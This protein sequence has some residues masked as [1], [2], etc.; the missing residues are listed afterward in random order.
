MLKIGRR[1]VQRSLNM[2]NL[3]ISRCCFVT[4][5]KQRQRNE[6]RIITHANTAIVLF[7]VVVK[8][9]LIKLLKI[10]HKRKP[11]PGRIKKTAERAEN[12]SAMNRNQEIKNDV[13]LR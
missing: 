9:Y 10:E 5:C 2:Q 3:T 12:I 13:P 7:A 6:Q 4:L 8:V 11:K 1:I